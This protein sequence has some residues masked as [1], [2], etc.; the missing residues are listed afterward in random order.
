VKHESN[1]LLGLVLALVLIGI[2]L[3][4]SA[5]AVD[6][7]SSSLNDSH[8]MDRLQRQLIYVSIGLVGL[9]GMARFDYHRLRDPFIFR[10]I[11]TVSLLLLIL[12]LVPGIGDT[13]KGAQRWLELGGFTFQPSELGKMALIL[14]LAVKLADNQKHITQFGKGFLPPAIITSAFAGLVL[15]EKDLGAPVVMFAVSYLM[16]FMAA[17]PIRYLVPSVIPAVGAVYALVITD[18]ERTERMTS[19]I[20]PWS[21]RNEGGYQLIQSMN[22]F[23][24]GKVWGKGP[25]AGEQ[26][27]YYLPDAHTDFIF[28]VWGEEMGLVGTLSVVALYVALF[29]VALRIALNARELFGSLL[30]GGIVCLV[31]TQAAVNIAVTTGLMPTKGLPLP[32]ISWGGSALIVF[33]TL[34][35]IVV[36]IGLQAVEPRLKAK[37]KIS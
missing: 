24:Q 13:R 2:F 10:M 19:F 17:V 12:V 11:V 16:M 29:A 7:L 25:G 31:V 5:S 15:L 6:P 33:M 9:F 30:A 35:G 34:M 8:A 4:Y 18:P 32:F 27:L 21:V 22:A 28:A 23:A 20:D 1:I 3:V 37:R 26:K 36:S 14:L